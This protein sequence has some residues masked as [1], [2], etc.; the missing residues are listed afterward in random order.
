VN[1]SNGFKVPEI[2]AAIKA[3]RG[4]ITRAAQKLGCSRRTMYRY[5]HRHPTVLQA[6]E[7]EREKRHDYVEDKLMQVI[8]DKS[9]PAIMFYL[10]T[11]G[12][13]R[14]YGEHSSR[15]ITGKDGRPIEIRANLDVDL[16][17]LSNEELAAALKTAA[18]L[19]GAQERAAQEGE[20]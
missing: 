13:A 16:T 10:R 5:I 14:G 8:E 3:E 15:E 18:I 9:V 12:R 20:G 19:G 17:G 1:N 4:F 2:I 6:L 11:I 7:D